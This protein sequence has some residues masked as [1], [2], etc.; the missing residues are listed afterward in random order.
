[1]AR[2]CQHRIVAEDHLHRD[3]DFSMLRGKLLHHS[4]NLP[5]N[6]SLA[7]FRYEAAVD[8]NLERIRNNIPLQATLRSVHVQPRSH[9]LSTPYRLSID[10]RPP[11]PNLYSQRFQILNQR[12]PI[13]DRIDTDPPAPRMSRSPTHRDQVFSVPETRDM[14]RLNPAICRETIIH[15]L[16]NHVL[17]N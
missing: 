7:F 6:L 15:I 2:R 8:E 5:P 13:L 1:M 12:R 11:L 17:V 4:R 10:S 14:Q 9:L 3:L 16:R